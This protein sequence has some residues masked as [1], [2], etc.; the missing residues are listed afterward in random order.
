MNKTSGAP[1]ARNWLGIVT[2][3][4]VLAILSLAGVAKPVVGI[5][6][7]CITKIDNKT[8]N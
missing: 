7:P 6:P 5:E 4:Y 8:R 1:K 3:V 2:F